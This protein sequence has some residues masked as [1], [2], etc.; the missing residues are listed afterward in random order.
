MRSL[1]SNPGSSDFGFWYNHLPPHSARLHTPPPQ[2]YFTLPPVGLLHP[3][4]SPPLCI[5][6]NWAPAAQFLSFCFC[7]L[8]PW[9]YF[10]LFCF[11]YISLI[12]C[13]T[14]RAILWVPVVWLYFNN[15]LFL[16]LKKSECQQCITWCSTCLEVVHLLKLRSVPL[17]S[18]LLVFYP[19]MNFYHL[20][21]WA[22]ALHG[23]YE[24]ASVFISILKLKNLYI[25]GCMQCDIWD[26]TA[27]FQLP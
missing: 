22:I 15:N 5:H 18:F 8:V 14:S 7:F 10:L 1:K 25:V 6:Q 4:M 17:L 11:I 20:V 19:L 3:K 26:I 24:S 23:M 13:S 16:W 12:V 27:Y 2:I 9:R 21:E